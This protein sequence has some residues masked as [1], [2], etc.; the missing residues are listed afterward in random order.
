MSRS[1]P[2][3]IPPSSELI[4]LCQSQIALLTQWLK[5]DWS[6]VYLTEGILEGSDTH[7]IPIA[8]YPQTESVWQSEA[9]LSVLPENWNR[10]TSSVPLLLGS[11]SEASNQAHSDAQVD[12]PQSIWKVSSSRGQH[13]IVFPL[14][15]EDR[16]M[17]LLVTGRKNRAW[18]RKELGQ[19]ENIAKT[20]ALACLLDRQQ[21]WYQQQLSQQSKIRRLQRDRLDSLLHQL[22]NPLTALRTFGKLL[23]KRLI[24][25][26][27][28]Q[29][30]IQGILRESDRLQELLQEFETDLDMTSTDTE[31]VTLDTN[32]LSL[33][34]ASSVS[35]SP[36]F[37]LG[38][39][40]N[41]EPVNVKDVLE[42][43]LISASA[44]AQEREIHLSV[45]LGDHLLPVQANFRALREVLSNLID[46]ALKYTPT[47]GTIQIEAGL[48]QADGT[49]N[50]Q[51]IAIRDTGYGIPP[52]DQAHIFERH[53]RGV[54]SQGNI[55][56]T[57]LGLAIVKELV[58]QMQGKIDLIS[59]N[60][61]SQSS[62][63]PGTTL[64]VWLA[65]AT[66]SSIS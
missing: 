53:Y 59:P 29:S 54:Q 5:A 49:K 47:G 38:N 13:Q 34:E 44:I 1:R 24:P 9:G 11:S 6:A 33:P 66:S 40:L 16:V 19:I 28:N 36:S 46:N 17:G 64:I 26:D 65:I 58:E 55:P 35:G 39:S 45:D 37:L 12:S 7:L 48:E 18:N 52:E 3:F 50:W 61:L 20:I 43:L 4:A 31:T 21:S 22:R 32:A 2:I 30:V 23:L 15:D 60:Q 10:I 63:Y 51:G 14:M 62:A 41:L 42:P 57:G 25:G 8:I 56:G 27:R